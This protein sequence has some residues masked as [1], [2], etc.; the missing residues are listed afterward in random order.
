MDPEYSNRTKCQKPISVKKSLVAIPVSAGASGTGLPYAPENWPCPG[1]IW[2]WKV[3]KRMSVHGYWI[4][5]YLYLPPRLLKEKVPTSGQ[6]FKSRLLVEQYIREKFPDVDVEAF[7]SSFIWKIPCKGQTA[8]IDGNVF[9]FIF[10]KRVQ[11]TGHSESETVREAGGC[12]AGNKM[13]NLRL[14]A[15]KYSLPLLDCDIC[16]GEPEF[17][18]DCCCILCCKTIDWAYGGYSFIRCEATVDESFICAHVAHLDCALR[19]YM[20]GTVGGSIGLDVEYY[21]RRCDH[22]TDLISHVM[23]LLHTCESLDSRDDIE[24]ILNLALC[25]LRGSEQMRVKSLQNRIESVMAKL[26]GVVFSKDIWK[27]EDNTLVDTAENSILLEN[28]SS[29]VRAL[30]DKNYQEDEDLTSEFELANVKD[31]VEERAPNPACITLNPCI[32]SRSLHDEIDQVLKELKMSQETEYRIAEEKLYAQKDFLLSLYQQLDIERDEVVNPM[33]SCNGGGV[34]L[35]MT[36]VSNTVD[37]IKVEESKL[38]RM[39]QIS[40]GFGQ[41]SKVILN[42]FFGLSLD[43]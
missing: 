36:D 35:L 43:D 16:C 38:K 13:C 22:K 11:V 18:R 20:A 24:K 21:C 14:Q 8:E 37:Q 31:I 40:R 3:G 17:C 1:D 33:P 15:R 41:T 30:H 4:D 10:P 26:R 12:K 39:M 23:R 6:H 28:G 2:R 9:S 27:L 42:D 5:R 32:T 19:T 29:L 25:I 7:F 34:D